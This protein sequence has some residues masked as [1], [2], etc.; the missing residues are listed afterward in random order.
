[1]FALYP[2]RPRSSVDRPVPP[3]IATIRGP[4]ARY[5]LVYSTS[6][7]EPPRATNGET[8]ERIRPQTPTAVI[9]IPAAATIAARTCG[10][11]HAPVS[12]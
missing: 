2:L 3:P 10:S 4:R 5:R 7:T 11:S 12:Q 9:A 1:M 6:I 8:T